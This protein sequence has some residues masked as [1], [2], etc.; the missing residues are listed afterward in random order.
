MEEKELSSDIMGTM[1]V[2]N[3]QHTSA[4]WTELVDEL[5]AKRY[6]INPSLKIFDFINDIS[7]STID[8]TKPFYRARIGKYKRVEDLGVPPLDKIIGGRLN[9]KAISHLYVATLIET[10]V[11]EV[12]PWIGATVSVAKCV[13]KEMLKIKD[14]TVD[15]GNKDAIND[16]KRVINNHFAVKVDPS[17]S[18]LD[19][20]ATQA[21]AEY[22]RDKGYD[23]IKYFSSTHRGGINITVFNSDKMSIEY[24]S[25]IEVLDINYDYPGKKAKVTVDTPS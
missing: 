5:K 25:Q 18:E 7:E 11:S 13:P 21:V 12:R 17:N 22:I 19:Y 9:P 1:Y 20:L 16:Y 23:G 3:D 14:F 15:S 6:F 2:T 24:L 8:Q 10:A 4:K